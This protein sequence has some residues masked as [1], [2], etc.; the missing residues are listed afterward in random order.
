MTAYSKAAKRRA[1][2][3][4]QK[5]TLPGG[6]TVKPRSRQGER[7]DLDHHPMQQALEARARQTGLPMDECHAQMM[8]CAVGR[9]LLIEHLPDR[10]DM[11]AAVKHARGVYAAHSRAIAAPSRHPK[12]ARILSP[13]T[14]MHADANSPPP[15]LRSE[16]ERDRA[17][18]TAMAA[19]SGWL[20]HTD[21]AARKAFVQHVIEERDLPIRD[22]AG[23]VMAL[24]CI[25]DGNK[26]RA[27]RVMKRKT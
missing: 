21:A 18:L 13:V 1:K 25:V 4:R 7:N 16:E 26:G 12:V 19:L 2:R 9:R 3:A 14:A 22:W 24:R 8:G 11:W 23:I 10:D 27:I 15:D 6:V 17:A 5:I 20:T